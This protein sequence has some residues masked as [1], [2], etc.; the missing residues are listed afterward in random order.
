M[1][2]IS[3]ENAFD[4]SLEVLRNW[5]MT[6][7]DNE[8]SALKEKFNEL[9]EKFKDP[10]TGSLPLTESDNFTRTLMKEFSSEAI[11]SKNDEDTEINKKMDDAW[12]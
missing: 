8:E 7:E 3:K 11:E 2:D 12:G 6:L 10:T 5:D 9:Y 1:R 4:A